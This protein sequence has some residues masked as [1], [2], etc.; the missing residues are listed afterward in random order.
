[1]PLSV[2]VSISRPEAKNKNKVC[3]NDDE[4]A[5]G[6]AVQTVIA[7]MDYSGTKVED[8]AF[9]AV[10]CAEPGQTSSEPPPTPNKRMLQPAGWR[11][12]RGGGMC[13]TCNPDNGDNFIIDVDAL[14]EGVRKLKKPVD[15]SVTHAFRTMEVQL[16][17]KVKTALKRSNIKC[18]KGVDVD[19]FVTFTPTD[20]F[21]TTHFGCS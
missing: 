11:F 7:D 5:L 2:T 8:H 17:D 15:T 21:A 1:L 20:S 13:R 19:V 3:D 10:V 18:L 4:V 14:D 6:V 16:A 12:V 9:T